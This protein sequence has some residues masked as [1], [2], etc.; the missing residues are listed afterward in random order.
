[1]NVGAAKCGAI[2]DTFVKETCKTK[3]VNNNPGPASKRTGIGLS[4]APGCR[5]SVSRPAISWWSSLVAR[6]DDDF[7]RPHPLNA[8]NR[9][10]LPLTEQSLLDRV[11]TRQK[12]K[13]C[14]S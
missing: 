2:S 9:K 8:R 11:S 13:W 6:R 1:M 7:H 10:A 3:F 12:S 5:L 14:A 4:A